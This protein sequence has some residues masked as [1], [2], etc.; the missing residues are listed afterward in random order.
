[1]ACGAMYLSEQD[2]AASMH[3]AVLRL[4]FE[5]SSKVI[6]PYHLEVFGTLWDQSNESASIGTK[7]GLSNYGSYRRVF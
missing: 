5:V 1:M 7:I 6:S 2:A 3:A 4:V